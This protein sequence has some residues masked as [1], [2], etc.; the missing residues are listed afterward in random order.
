M[1]VKSECIAI[2]KSLPSNEETRHWLRVVENYKMG[3]DDISSFTH[4][5][6]LLAHK[7][8]EKKEKA[9]MARRER[10]RVAREFLYVEKGKQK[11]KEKAFST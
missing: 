6:E 9:A 1:N 8:Y 11:E 7:Y 2:L 5:A 3:E 10:A 4:M